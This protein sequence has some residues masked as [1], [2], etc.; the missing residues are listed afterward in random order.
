MIVAGFGFR[1]TASIDS[2]IDAFAVT[3]IETVDAVATVDDKSQTPA[4]TTFAK[5]IGAQIISVTAQNLSDIDTPT[6]SLASQ[7]HRATGSV[8]EAAALAGAGK[9]AILL[10]PRSI[11]HDRMA[12]CAIAQGP[13][14]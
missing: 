2:L 4:F 14:T 8:A 11:S 9:D 12:T 3:G 6:Q 1:S 5:A 7:T 13:N 10:A